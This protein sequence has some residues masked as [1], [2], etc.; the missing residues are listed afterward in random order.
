MFTREESSAIRQEF[1]TTFGKYMSPIPSSAGIKINW[2]NYH[3]RIKDVLFRMDAGA[4]SAT[5]AIVIQ[6]RDPGIQQLYYEQFLE[7][8]D[9]LHAELGEAW[10]WQLHLAEGSERVV[11]RIFQE[12]HGVSVFNR[13]HWPALIS[14]FKPRIIALDTFWENAKYTFEGLR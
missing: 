5:I 6:H 4:K 13:D 10:Q 11:S 7:L 9:L 2:V 1:W 12:L 14:F 3:T 8:K